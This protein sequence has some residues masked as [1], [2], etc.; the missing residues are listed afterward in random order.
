M[1]ARFRSLQSADRVSQQ[2]SRD[3]QVIRHI[4][5]GEHLFRKELPRSPQGA[6]VDPSAPVES[7]PFVCVAARKVLRVHAPSVRAETDRVIGG[8]YWRPG[9]L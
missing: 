7:P 2:R 1:Y 6:E 8:V 5:F 3:V 9:S 4:I